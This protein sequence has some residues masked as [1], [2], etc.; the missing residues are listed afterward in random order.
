MKIIVNGSSMM[1]SFDFERIEIFIKKY[2][3][4]V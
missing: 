4:I 1:K 2:I 3:F